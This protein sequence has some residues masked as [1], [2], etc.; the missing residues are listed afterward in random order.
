MG[1]RIRR[2]EVKE[3]GFVMHSGKC[4]NGS[5]LR[6]P[7]SW[8]SSAERQGSEGAHGEVRSIEGYKIPPAGGEG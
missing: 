4:M 5:C 3:M 2:T 6:V 7:E 1:S 8:T